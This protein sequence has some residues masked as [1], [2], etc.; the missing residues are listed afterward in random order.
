MPKRDK[1]LT[2]ADLKYGQRYRV[3]WKYLTPDD[4]W[5]AVLRYEAQDSSGAFVFS[6]IALDYRLQAEDI[7]EVWKTNAPLWNTAQ[8]P[9]VERRII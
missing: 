5:T 7:I 9:Y 1:K 6:T 4:T 8:K 3:V 2:A